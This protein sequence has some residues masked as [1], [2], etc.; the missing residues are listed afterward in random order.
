MSI[1]FHRAF[2]T[3]TETGDPNAITKK[4]GVASAADIRMVIALASDREGLQTTTS[5]LKATFP[6]AELVGCTTAGQFTEAGE[7]A[8][9]A[10]VC[11]LGADI[12]VSARMADGL[13]TSAVATVE[14]VADGL[15]APVDGFSYRTGLLLLDPAAGN[16][17]VVTLMTAA[18]LGPDVPLVGG[19]VGGLMV[20]S[21]AVSHG[22]AVQEDGLVLA[23]MHTKKPLSVGI[24]HGQRPM[25][26][27]LVVTRSTGNVVHELDGAPAWDVWKQ[28][29]ESLASDKS[30]PIPAKDDTAAMGTFFLHYQG[31]LRLGDGHK[32]RFPARVDGDGSI[33][34]L[35][36][37]PKGTV[38]QVMESDQDSQVSSARQAAMAASSR[39]DGPLAGALVFDCACR[40]GLLGD[41]FD[42][43]VEAIGDAMPGLVFGGFE[44]MGEVALAVGD[45][46]GFHNTTTVVV[47]FPAD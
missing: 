43:A 42:R 27:G 20:G 41:Q 25:S 7:T 46:S 39:A 32:V 34:F 36:G 40:K 47:G 12:R 15:A 38:L 22:K 14:Q 11:A 33:A 8:S 28:T 45:M 13:A 4:L 10:V 16:S 29:V 18:A 9:G 5:S 21:A 24:A 1:S 19:A 6:E 31:G 37:M 23:V 3:P 44:T 35:C 26:S 2:V 30:Y 17:E